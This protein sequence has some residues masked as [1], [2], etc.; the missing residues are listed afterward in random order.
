[1]KRYL[2]F[3][4]GFI[5]G[6]VLF[7]S[8]AAVAAGIIAKPTTSKV[9]VNGNEVYAEVYNINDNNYF[10]L[11]DV[12]QVV[13][14][15]VVWDDTDNRILINTSRGYTPN[16]TYTPP[17]QVVDASE[18]TTV[19]TIDELKA[20]FIRLTNNERVKAGLPKLEVLPIL[21]DTAQT[22]ADDMRINKYYAH[23]SPVYGTPGEMMKS[24]IPKLKSCAENLVHWRKTPQ[25]AIA[26]L[27]DSPKHHEIILSPK[28]T[29][30]GVGIFEVPSG[31]YWWVQHFAG[32]YT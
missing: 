9:I 17:A 15:S 23:E 28:Y 1:M 3:V 22:K 10:K 20:E 26:S 27:I 7:G 4:L 24:A 19:A 30:I 31:G 18:L 21:M 6:A 29:Y 13:D 12:A 14:F 25:D 2:N 5:I 32:L 8:T 16:E 11:R